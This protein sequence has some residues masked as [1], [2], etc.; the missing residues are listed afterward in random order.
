MLRILRSS[1][2][3][4][5]VAVEF[6]LDDRANL[7]GADRSRHEGCGELLGEIRDSLGLLMNHGDFHLSSAADGGT[8]MPELARW[9]QVHDDVRGSTPS[10]LRS[11]PQV[12]WSRVPGGSLFLAADSWGPAEPMAIGKWVVARSPKQEE[13]RTK[14]TPE[15][16]PRGHD[17]AHG[18]RS[19][20]GAR[21]HWRLTTTRPGSL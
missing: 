8:T 18:R 4:G 15:P 11:G 14:A 17:V 2:T 12:R 6:H 3:D 19:L 10:G 21:R 20:S 7:I 16:P 1:P 5:G 13:R 9:V